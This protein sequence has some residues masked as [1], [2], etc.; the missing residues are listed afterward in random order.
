MMVVLAVTLIPAGLL[1]ALVAFVGSSV[2]GAVTPL[3]A[4]A[5]AA[6]I[7][8]AEAWIALFLTSKAFEQ[9]DVTERTS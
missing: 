5:G 2:F 8:F 6:V 7:T 3:V 9:L 1:V 4:G